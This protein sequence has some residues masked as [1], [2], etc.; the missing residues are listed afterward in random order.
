MPMVSA[1]GYPT[2]DTPT[3]SPSP[4]P[5][6]DYQSIP[7]ATPNAFGAQIGAAQERLGGAFEQ[8]GDQLA[9]VALQRQ[10]LT[11]QVASDQATNYTMDQVTKIL[12]GDPNVPGDVGFYGKK[13]IDAVNS[14]Q[15][16]AKALDDIIN[17]TRATL[18][19]PR[20]QLE[21]D[22][23]TRRMRN[24]WMG[25]IGRHYDQQ[26]TVSAINSAKAGQDLAGQGMSSAA[27]NGDMAGFSLNVEALMKAKIREGQAQGW[28]QE[29]YD[30]ALGDV[31]AVATKQWVESTAVKDP[32]AAKE[33]L[34]HNKDALRGDEYAQL[35][36]MVKDHHD[37]AV[38]DKFVSGMQGRGGG[39]LVRG[40]AAGRAVQYEAA[41]PHATQA[42]DT[43][44][45]AGWTDA[46]IQGAL[47]NGQNEGGFEESWKPGDNGTSFGHW[48]FHRG[49]EYEGFMQ[50]SGGAATTQKQAEYVVQRMEQIHPGFG[51][52][53][54]PKQ[55]A[56]IMEAEF[57][58]PKVVTRNRYQGPVSV[59]GGAPDTATTTQT[60]AQATPAAATVPAP[61]TRSGLP[62]LDQQFDEIDKSSLTDDQKR[63][64]KDNATKRTSALEMAAQRAERLRVE[65]DRLQVQ[66]AADEVAKD[67]YSANPKITPAMIAN[68][69]RLAS[70]FAMRDH[71]I[72][73]VND[74]PGSSVPTHQSNAL[75]MSLIERMQPNYNKPDKITSMD[76][77]M[78]QTK[79]LNRSDWTFVNN[80]FH[81]QQ[82]LG[83]ETIR[84]QR[85]ELL[86]NY[87]GQIVGL[88]N[89]PHINPEG[90][91]RLYRYEHFI[92]SR[93]DEYQKA[94]KN[95]QELFDPKSPNF[96]GNP[97]TL[98]SFGPTANDLTKAQ[99]NPTADLTKIPQGDLFAGVTQGKYRRDLVVLEIERRLR[100][101][102]MQNPQVA[103]IR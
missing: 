51:K 19:N 65:H 52:I 6:P 100:S 26:L 7:A 89:D 54:D 83:G 94:G 79:G 101:G 33:F 24:Y 64:A 103:P 41:G 45:K 72:R 9:A 97:E 57:E 44:K 50:F 38:A 27:A 99:G 35:S 10:R 73:F 23:Q 66:A 21:F 59:G 77:I 85:A 3:V 67:V 40:G 58:R 68:D 95:P 13:G 43:F 61:E 93:V 8:A 1:A 37:A 98:K 18:T 78:E 74:P 31:R 75:A 60:V 71:L 81:A 92:Q 30:A 63:I 46:A 86:A 11:N 76:Q 47:A 87:K 102:E 56:D 70:N 84:Q 96:L 82:Q 16:T 28:T 62:P 42:V 55:A 5:G 91:A 17:K 20:Q 48:Q 53:T 15:S 36:R 32:A 34:E 39:G 29:Q 14:R 4:T 2:Q 25:E 22:N 88:I 12:H 49:G 69:P 90:F 80:Q